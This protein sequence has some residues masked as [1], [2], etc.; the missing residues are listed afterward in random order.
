MLDQNQPEPLIAK[1][2]FENW[3]NVRQVP[4]LCISIKGGLSLA[5]G[6]S[7]GIIK[8]LEE[9]KITPG[10]IIASSSA[11]IPFTLYSLGYSWKE[12]L[13]SVADFKLHNLFSHSAIFSHQ[14][15]ISPEHYYWYLLRHIPNLT[16]IDAESIFRQ[17]FAQYYSKDIPF[18]NTP[19]NLEE[20]QKRIGFKLRAN[21]RF[22]LTDMKKRKKRIFKPETVHDFVAGM[23]ASSSFPLIAPAINIG[24]EYF[25]DGDL[26]SGYGVEE[27]KECDANYVI[28]VSCKTSDEEGW[29]LPI[30]R[31]IKLGQVDVPKRIAQ[32]NERISVKMPKGASVFSFERKQLELLVTNAFDAISSSLFAG[33]YGEM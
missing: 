17:A 14:S 29:V 26:I 2:S 1:Y 24:P 32:P 9:Q 8:W 28:G 31:N 21:L 27:A 11:T 22:Q 20:I 18:L 12:I 7:I 30:M 3:E 13:E 16:L 23:V 33:G 10:L 15:L 19:T 5:F 25:T 6:A 4:D